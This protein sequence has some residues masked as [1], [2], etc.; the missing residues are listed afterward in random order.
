MSRQQ[1]GSVQNHTKA[2]IGLLLMTS[3]V[4][5]RS[6]SAPTNPNLVGEVKGDG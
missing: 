2:T 3:L 6:A 5:K 1:P 4:Y